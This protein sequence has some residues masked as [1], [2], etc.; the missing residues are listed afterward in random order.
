MSSKY[1]ESF[2]KYADCGDDEIEESDG[3]AKQSDLRG[4]WNACIE[5]ARRDDAGTL[6]RSPDEPQ[7]AIHLR[8]CCS[9]C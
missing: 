1:F 9:D 6:I 2:T 8:L 5:R 7:S 4:D 3:L